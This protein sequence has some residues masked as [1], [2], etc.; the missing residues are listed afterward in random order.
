MPDEIPIS[1][2]DM[3]DRGPHSKEVLDFFLQNGKAILG[4]HEHMMLDHFNGGGEYQSRMWFL[5]GGNTT[6]ESLGIGGE[7]RLAELKATMKESPFPGATMYIGEIK[8]ARA[9]FV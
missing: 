1:V 5:N 4:N 2:G 7:K 9:K 8:A 3:I 6:L